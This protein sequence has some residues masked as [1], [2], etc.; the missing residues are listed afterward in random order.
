MKNL[1]EGDDDVSRCCQWNLLR[2]ALDVH[3]KNNEF[4]LGFGTR[5]KVNESYI[6]VKF[7]KLWP[8]I[9]NFPL[10]KFEKI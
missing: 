2:R 3:T 5:A 6:D 8:N 10:N 9:L 4:V 7:K 1:D